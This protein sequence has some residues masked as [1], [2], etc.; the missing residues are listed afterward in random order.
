MKKIIIFGATGDIGRYFINYLFE[1]KMN[2]QFKII[3]S[4]TKDVP[5]FIYDVEYIQLD[6]V[7]AEEFIKLPQQDV[8]AIVDFAGA[9]PARMQG[10]YP[11]RYI[12]VNIKGTFNIMEYAKN[13]KVE[14][15]LYMQSFGDIKENSEKDVNL[16][17]NSPCKFSLNNDHS[18]YVLT[19][20]F[21][22]DMIESYHKMYGISNFIF[23]LP[24][25]YLYSP[26]DEY[27]VDGI[28]RKIGYRILIDKARKGENL[29]VWGDVNRLKDMIYV[30]DLC[31]MLDLALKSSRKTGHFNVGTGIGTPLIDQIKG[32]INVFDEKKQSKIILCPEKPNAPQYIMNVQNA[33]EEL[34][35]K[36]E[37]DYI[38]MLKDMKKYFDG[39]LKY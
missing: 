39:E 16:T 34:G 21:A 17:I 32:I 8:Y 19:K 6:I 5:N 14:K 24:T 1:N 35:Y 38:S 18:I 2:E 7:N 3:A 31:R 37:Y 36:P 25:I 20:N 23:R 29:E 10:Y 11:E 30:K 13:I 26:I 27:Y 33:I 28:K 15:I 9:M 12:D 22:V 4:G